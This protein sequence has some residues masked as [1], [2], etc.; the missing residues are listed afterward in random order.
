[1][2]EAKKEKN[3]LKVLMFYTRKKKWKNEKYLKKYLKKTG[4]SSLSAQLIYNYDICEILILKSRTF[5]TFER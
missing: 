2:S 1:M 5:L 3:M 4:I